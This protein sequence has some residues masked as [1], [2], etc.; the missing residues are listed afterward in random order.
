MGWVWRCSESWPKAQQSRSVSPLKG[1]GEHIKFSTI[2]KTRIYTQLPK[3]RSGKQQRSQLQVSPRTHYEIGP[4]GS[5]CHERE[6]Q[7]NWEDKTWVCQWQM[8]DQLIAIRDEVTC[9]VDEGRAEISIWLCFSN[10]FDAASIIHLE[11]Y[12]MKWVL[13]YKDYV[14]HTGESGSTHLGK[15]VKSTSLSQMCRHW[16]ITST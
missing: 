11:N 8:F 16:Y 2:G 10:T 13:V 12:T 1:C 7:D 15:D 5:C 9:S 4:Y 3:R 14:Y 6:R